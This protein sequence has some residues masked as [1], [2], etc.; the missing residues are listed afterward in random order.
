MADMSAVS[1]C[2]GTST[3]AVILAKGVHVFLHEPVVPPPDE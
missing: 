1:L 2:R 3:P